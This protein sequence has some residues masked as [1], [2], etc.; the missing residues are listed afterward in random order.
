MRVIALA[1]ACLCAATAA[2]ADLTLVK[3]GQPASVIVL[4]AK[5]TPSAELAAKKLQTC[6]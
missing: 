2:V 6:L 4:Q 1:I 3:D 5:P